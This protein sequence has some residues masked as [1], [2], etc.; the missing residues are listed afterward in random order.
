MCGCP[1]GIF[2]LVNQRD[3]EG[4]LFGNLR[5]VSGETIGAAGTSYDLSVELRNQAGVFIGCRT[6]V[7][8]SVDETVLAKVCA[9]VKPFLRANS[10]L[11]VC[12]L[13]LHTIEPRVLKYVR[14]QSF[15]GSLMSLLFCTVAGRTARRCSRRMRRLKA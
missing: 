4:R 1:G 8:L 11:S 7:I 10:R 6:I 13:P 3:T 2:E 14:D 15:V 12:T 5:V 9:R